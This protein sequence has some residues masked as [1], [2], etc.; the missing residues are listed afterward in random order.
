MCKLGLYHE[1]CGHCRTIAKEIVNVWLM[2]SDMII[3]SK[4]FCQHSS[5]IHWLIDISSKEDGTPYDWANK[6]TNSPILGVSSLRSTILP[7]TPDASWVLKNPSSIKLLSPP[8]LKSRSAFV[9]MTSAPLPTWLH[10]LPIA[11]ITIL[12]QEYGLVLIHILILQLLL[13]MA[14][15]LSKGTLTLDLL[16]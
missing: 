4:H 2:A 14:F 8:V 15:N 16:L 9:T 6:P 5:I 12:V 3:V 13:D 10:I 1:L 11:W 7:T